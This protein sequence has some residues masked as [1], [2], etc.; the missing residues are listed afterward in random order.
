VGWIERRILGFCVRGLG[1]FGTV[2]KGE[3]WMG[4]MR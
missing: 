1:I 4:F 2:S 3:V